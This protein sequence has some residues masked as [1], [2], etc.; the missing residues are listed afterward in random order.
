MCTDCFIPASNAIGVLGRVI[1]SVGCIANFD[2]RTVTLN[3]T[4]E[5]SRVETLSNSALNLFFL[6]RGRRD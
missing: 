1:K 3:N 5:D 6:Q 4:L 2:Y